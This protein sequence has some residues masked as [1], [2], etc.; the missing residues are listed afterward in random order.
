MSET[1]FAMVSDWMADGN[2]NDFVKAHPGVNRLALVGSLSGLYCLRFKLVDD[3]VTRLAGRRRSG[4]DVHP[5][6][7]NDPW[8]SQRGAASTPRATLIPH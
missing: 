2:I 1:Q 7:G 6:S 8:G 3:R 5:W 4:L